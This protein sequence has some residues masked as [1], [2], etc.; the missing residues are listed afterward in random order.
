[1]AVNSSMNGGAKVDYH[2]SVS[3]EGCPISAPAILSAFPADR[4]RTGLECPLD[5]DGVHLEMRHHAHGLRRYAVGQ[6]A[7]FLTSRMLCS[8]SQTFR[9]ASLSRRNWSA[10][11]SE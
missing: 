8:F 11:R 9:V 5:H 4:V 3:S 7:A 6:N 1:M 10:R 2:G